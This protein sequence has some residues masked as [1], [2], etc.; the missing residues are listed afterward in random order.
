MFRLRMGVLV[1]Q[2]Y[3]LN[4]ERLNAGPAPVTGRMIG[5]TRL[6]LRSIL[7]SCYKLVNAG[8]ISTSHASERARPGGPG[9]FTNALTPVI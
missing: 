3:T 6:A 2:F 4:R 8:N 7:K 5:R 1:E 9:L